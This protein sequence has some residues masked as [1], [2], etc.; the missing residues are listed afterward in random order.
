MSPPPH[1]SSLRRR[2]T[3]SASVRI[4]PSRRCPCGACTDGEEREQRREEGHGEHE[5]RTDPERDK[6][7]ELPERRYLGEVHAEESER[8]RQAREEDGLKIDAHRFDDRIAPRFAGPEARE[9]GSFAASI[10]KRSGRVGPHGV[11]EGRVDVDAIGDCDGQHDDRRDGGRRRHREPDPP[12]ESHRG[13]DRKRDDEH[14][15]ER[16]AEPPN[17]QEENQRHRREARRDECLQIVQRHLHEGLVEDREAGD[18]NVDAGEAFADLVLESACELG[19]PEAFGQCVFARELHGDVDAADRAVAGDEA[20]G[21]TRFGEGDGPDPGPLAGIAG[22]RLVHEI[23]YQDVV[24]VRR[25]VLEVGDGVDAG[26]IRDLPGSFGEPGG[27]FEREGGGGVAVLRHD[28]EE[29]VAALRVGVLHRLVREE[30]RVVPRE[31]DPVVGRELEKRRPARRDRDEE[32]GD[33]DDRPPR[34]DDPAAES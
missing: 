27:G 24:A 8:R 17:Q 29:Y 7:S 4:A 20:P 22:R 12:A 11:N 2:T 9:R 6:V 26:R 1:R 15:C 23:A 14:D 13:H 3:N 5:R 19:D 33:G 10:R 34:H 31:V 32:Q 16:P 30:L 28:G 25:R 21:E 18:S